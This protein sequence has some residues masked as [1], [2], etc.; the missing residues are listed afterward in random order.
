V[1]GETRHDALT[2]VVADDQSLVRVGLRTILDHEPD[3][4]VVGEAADGVEAVEQARRL[5]PDVV[6]MDVRMPRLDGIG[7]TRSIVGGTNGAS[8]VLMLTT[9]DLDAYVY[10]ALA[11]GA[12]GFVLKDMPRDQLVNAVRVV[13]TGDSL[14]APAVTRRLIGKFLDHAPTRDAEADPRLQRLSRREKEVLRLVAQGLSNAEIA[15]RLVLSSTTV[16]SHVA[17]VLHKLELRDRVQA[18]V[19]AFQ[20]GLVR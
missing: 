5:R 1:S 19:L 4:Q 11:A 16:K 10:E 13:A 12:S 2:V 3:L 14:L 20:T 7:A 15:E 8:R 18:V 9:F 17:S 6:L